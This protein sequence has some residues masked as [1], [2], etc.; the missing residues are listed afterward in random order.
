MAEAAVRNVIFDFGGVLVR[1]R[2]DEILE[3][4]YEDERLRRL[5]RDEVFNHPDW[6]ELDRGTLSDEAAILRFAAR[7]GRPAAEMHALMAHVRQSLVALEASHVLVGA[8]AA[9]GIPL[10]GLSNMSSPTFAHLK[11]R[12]DV[13]DHFRGIVLSAEI[14]QVKPDP[15]IFEH[16][17]REFGLIPEETVFIDDHLPNIESARRLG[18]KTIHFSSAE[19]AARELEAHLSAQ[20]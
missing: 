17:C 19:Q 9:R 10:Y 6:V 5:A 15:E 7:M 12:Y 2:P 16:I 18:F 13:W 20:P 8:L 3:T 14:K 4:F 1:W 11:D